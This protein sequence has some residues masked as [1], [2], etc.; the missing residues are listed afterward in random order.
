MRYGYDNT[1]V[2]FVNR[3][4]NVVRGRS[5][6]EAVDEF[7]ATPG[8]ETLAAALWFEADKLA[9]WS[10]EWDAVMDT[11]APLL[12]HLPENGKP[13]A[14]A[15]IERLHD[16]MVSKAADLENKIFLATIVVNAL[17]AVEGDPKNLWSDE[18]LTGKVMA[19]FDRERNEVKGAIE[20]R[21][22]I[23]S[24]GVLKGRA[25]QS[26]KKKIGS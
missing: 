21:Y 14:Q 2:S 6:D 13:D 20:H 16:E 24:F 8:V 1:A 18:E 5:D 11:Y 3:A 15:Q 4:W 23:S 7:Y 19:E 10:A 25:S 26:R 9:D 22:T 12:D 17:L